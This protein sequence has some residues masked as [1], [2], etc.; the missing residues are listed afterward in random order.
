M[1]ENA[2]GQ[3]SSHTPSTIKNNT[4]AKVQNIPD[5]RKDISIVLDYFRC[6]SGTSLDCSLSTGILRNS[7]T[8]HIDTLQKLGL[9]QVVKIAPDKH[10][11]YKAK[12]YSADP[13]RW[14]KPKFV[15]LSL[16]GE[17]NL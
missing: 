10:T 12:Y 14:Q 6:I 13:A 16:F 4:G 1:K 5:T 9:I 7:V 17:G 3:T 15:Q 8:F 2:K 11:G